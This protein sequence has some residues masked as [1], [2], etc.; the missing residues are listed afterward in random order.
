MQHMA[1]ECFEQI[2]HHAGMCIAGLSHLVQL[3]HCCLVVCGRLEEQLFNL[4]DQCDGT[5]EKDAVESR[6]HTPPPPSLSDASRHA[7]RYTHALLQKQQMLYA[8]VY[9]AHR[10]PCFP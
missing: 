7:Q 2:P 9:I 6:S 5:A 10:A 8:S 1:M 4:L 3:L